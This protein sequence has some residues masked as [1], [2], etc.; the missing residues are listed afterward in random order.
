[1]NTSLHHKLEKAVFF[2]FCFILWKS[3]KGAYGLFKMGQICNSYRRDEF[4]GLATVM[5]CFNLR[6]AGGCVILD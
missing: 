1:M 3:S 2:S 5:D 6:E 4:Q